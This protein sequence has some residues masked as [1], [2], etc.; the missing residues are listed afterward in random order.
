M[1]P[2]SWPS[3]L[4]LFLASLRFF[5]IHGWFGEDLSGTRGIYHYKDFPRQYI[6]L[7]KATIDNPNIL[8]MDRFL[9]IIGAVNHVQLLASSR[10]RCFRTTN[11][12]LDV[13]RSYYRW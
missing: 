12:L 3:F 13:H 9:I 5:P 11:R 2:L 6:F 8:P 7:F 1:S 10:C 4:F